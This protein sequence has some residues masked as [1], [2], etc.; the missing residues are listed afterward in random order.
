MVN[1]QS[2]PV[3]CAKFYAI[4]YAVMRL[5]FWG[6]IKSHFFSVWN[7]SLIFGYNKLQH[8][9]N[10]FSYISSIVPYAPCY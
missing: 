3:I 6:K 10:Y 8:F 7:E 9:Q 5:T 2:P 1:G 4:K